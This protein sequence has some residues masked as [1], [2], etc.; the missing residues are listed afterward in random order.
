MHADTFVTSLTH[1]ANYTV[2]QFGKWYNQEAEFCR[3]GYTPAWYRGNT[4]TDGFGL[5]CEE[6]VYFNYS[7]NVNGE[8]IVRYGDSPSDYMTAVL[9]NLTLE[10]L[11]TATEGD[12]PWFAYVA[13]HAPHL[14]ALPAPW[15]QN[16]TIP[17][18]A[19]GNGAAP[20]FPNFN[21]GWEGKHFQ[22]NN[23]VDKPMSADLIAGSDLLWA[24]RLRTL[25]SV[26][27]LVRDAIALL[28]AKGALDNTYVIFTSDHGYHLGSWGVWSEK[29]G[30]EDIDAQVLLGIRGPQVGQA[31]STDAL[32]SMNVDL[33]ATILELAG[34]PNGWPD[35]QGR[36]DGSSLT[37]LLRASMKEP[38][39]AKGRGRHVNE[40][41]EE[42]VM[43]EELKKREKEL[44]QTKTQTQT[45]AAAATEEGVSLS[46]VFPP[47][48]GWRDRVLV[49]FV[50]W[51]T[52]F[53]W[54]A[55]CQ[56]GLAPDG[57]PCPP[58]NPNPPA[59]LVNSASNV[60]TALRVR[61]MTA[62]YLYAEYRP[63]KAALSPEATNWTEVYNVTDDI[64]QI[65]NLWAS[66]GLSNATLKEM[67]NELWAVATCSGASCP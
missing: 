15:Y 46:S 57:A 64:W 63:P 59:G 27:D 60:Y 45:A 26:D 51:T 48:S 7:L 20:R 49:Q 18:S 23:G 50:G 44:D 8:E 29:A 4:T 36:R 39:A 41:K 21:T 56:W 53:E 35:G 12:A 30:P 61:N 55:P 34:I 67:A 1:L 52:P 43:V 54:L 25:M 62:N 58:D 66:G 31:T 19:N 17:P 38:P 10:W 33:P 22:V 5:L 65:N 13:P 6:G 28:E 42:V 47:P 3:P 2:G 40:T 11:N 32:V 16:A 24:R 37:P 9:G 14:P